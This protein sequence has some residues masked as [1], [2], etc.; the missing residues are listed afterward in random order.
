M[1]WQK[2]RSTEG[3]AISRAG[4]Q[5]GGGARWAATSTLAEPGKPGTERVALRALSLPSLLRCLEEGRERWR[6]TRLGHQVSK[7]GMEREVRRELARRN[8][9]GRGGYEG[10]KGN[11]PSSRRVL[12]PPFLTPPPPPPRPPHPLAISVAT[13]SFCNSTP[14]RGGPSLGSQACWP[15]LGV[16]WLFALPLSSLSAPF[17]SPLSFALGA[18]RDPE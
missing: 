14:G 5:W 8:P 17:S 16:A 15:R 11:F 7:V 2:V 6:R 1:N 3:S 4:N 18:L 9:S 12:K 10:K 13:G